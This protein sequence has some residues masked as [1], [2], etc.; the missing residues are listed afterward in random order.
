MALFPVFLELSGRRC[1]VVGGGEAGRRKAAAA[2]DAEADVV[3]VDPSHSA[4]LRAFAKAHPAIR[5]EARPFDPR[6]VHGAALVFA[7]TGDPEVDERVAAAAAASGIP[8]CLAAHAADV[9]R[10]GSFTT[11]AVLRR[12]PVVVAVSTGAAAPGLAGLLRDRIAES[13]GETVGDE[14]ALLGALRDSLHDCVPDA[15]R[16]RAAMRAALRSGAVDLLREGRTEE[17]EAIVRRILDDAR[18]G[19][20]LGPTATAVEEGTR[21]TR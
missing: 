12:A 4:G 9:A 14:A 8:F 17:A 5:L 18:S 20:E 13:L 10:G 19:R 16:R 21:C 3:I 2:L 11:G 7:C 15:A 6:D 1:L